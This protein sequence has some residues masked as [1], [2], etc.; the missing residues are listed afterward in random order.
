MAKPCR[1]DFAMLN[2]NKKEKQI[3][4]QTRGRHVI[5]LFAGCGKQCS[6]TIYFFLMDKRNLFITL[7]L[8][9]LT[10]LTSCLSDDN[11]EVVYYD[12][13]AITSFSI[14]TL[15]RTVYS[16][17]T[18]GKDTVIESSSDYSAYAFTI[19]HDNGYIYN[20]DSLPTNVHIDKCL[21]TVYAKNSGYVYVKNIDNDSLKAVAADSVDFTVPRV[22]RCYANDGSWYRDYTVEVRV[23]K[24][25][26]DSLYWQAK[27]TQEAFKGLEGLRGIAFR[28]KLIAYGMADGKGKAFVT[29]ANDGNTWTELPLKT[30]GE[31]SMVTNGVALFAL[32]ANG[33]LFS[34][35]DGEKW[36][37]VARQEGLTT[38]MAASRSELYALSA[39]GRMMKSASFGV[40]WVEDEL[41][42]GKNNLPK[43][44][45]T[46]LMLQA[47]TNA[48]VDK[49]ILIGNRGVEEDST[50]VVWS[51]VVDNS[52]SAYSQKWMYQPFTQASWHKAPALEALCVVYYEG[53]MLLMGGKG[54]GTCK[55]EPYS[56]I[57]SSTDNGLTWYADERYY[58]PEGFSSLYGTYALV[59]DNDNHLWILS[60]AT[61]QV[62]RGYLSQLTWK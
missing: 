25:A 21:P 10:M 60:G 9:T 34:S 57:L 52:S 59:A 22:L 2:G 6:P 61:G 31:L 12:D 37:E 39:D 30:E 40:S 45:I 3:I 18:A 35:E 14:G 17:T 11:Q 38:L 55:E 47:K 29:S 56:K 49:V 48:D 26:Q 50:A 46:G 54:I 42:A 5:R 36:Q 8:A 51:K 15:T 1:D 44:D 43:R 32:S 13:A 19:D 7:I 27:A 33:M 62:W 23:H 4:H 53:R 16:K 28:D 41:E 58:M 20:L 24:E